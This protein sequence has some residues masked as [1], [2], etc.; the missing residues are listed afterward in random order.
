MVASE[1]GG[2]AVRLRGHALLTPRRDVDAMA[3]VFFQIAG[4]P[5]KARAQAEQGRVWIEAE[6]RRDVAFEDW[7]QVFAEEAA[8]SLLSGQR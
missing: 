5:D 6:C 2:M 3:E 8:G 7:R 4:Y 1:V